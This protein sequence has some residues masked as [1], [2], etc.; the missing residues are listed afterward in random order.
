MA[1]IKKGAGGKVTLGKN[2]SWSQRMG[3]KAP[4]A[5]AKSVKTSKGKWAKNSKDAAAKASGGKNSNTEDYYVKKT[6]TKR[7]RDIG[8]AVPKGYMRTGGRYFAKVANMRPI[9]SKTSQQ[10]RD[11]FYA[12]KEKF[13][14]PKEDAGWMRSI[15]NQGMYNGST[16]EAN[17]RKTAGAR[18]IIDA[19]GGTYA[20]DWMASHKTAGMKK[21]AK[22]RYIMAIGQDG[23]VR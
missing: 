17:F 18:K 23:H 8:Q 12:N 5:S 4:S 13:L 10:Q 19:D 1:K 3:Q 2:K 9:K 22:S 11:L 14:G 7:I 6:G 15:G 16:S 21:A 20:P